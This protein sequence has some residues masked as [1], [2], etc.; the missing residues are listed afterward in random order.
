MAGE[1]IVIPRGNS[2]SASRS[3]TRRRAASTR[4]G[5][6]T[7]SPPAPEQ[8]TASSG[9]DS[10]FDTANMSQRDRLRE[11]ARASPRMKP[12]SNLS[13]SLATL[14]L[15][16]LMHICFY[17][18]FLLNTDFEKQDV[19]DFQKASDILLNSI[20]LSHYV[21]QGAVLYADPVGFL[22]N[23]RNNRWQGARNSLYNLMAIAGSRLVAQYCANKW[24][25]G[26]SVF[27]L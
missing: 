23:F 25:E 8:A 1:Y 17:I 12:G 27:E 6:A 11:L 15:I 14:G 13:E 7:S 10:G 21:G 2:S 5:L 20:S 26:R 16:F 24:F 3:S 19:K 22:N 9:Y 4:G 18:R